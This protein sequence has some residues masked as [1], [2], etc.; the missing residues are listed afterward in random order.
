MTD[1]QDSAIS[2]LDTVCGSVESVCLSFTEPDDD[3]VPVMQT[4]TPFG[5]AFQVYTFGFDVA[6][7]SNDMAKDMLAHQMMVPLIESTGAKL[8]ATVFSTWMLNARVTKDNLVDG[9]YVG[10]RP[11]DSPDRIEAVMVSVIAPTRITTR[12]AEII[13]D[14]VN[15]PTL[16]A[17]EQWGSDGAVVFTGRFTEPLQ[18]ALRDSSGKVDL[19][20]MEAV[21]E[22][23][24]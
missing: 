19:Q 1:M 15:P 16:S 20:R 4:A 12:H 5:D 21:F 17:W 10:P 14:E 7:L 8:V 13:R 9:R 24:Q 2:F 22:E 18:D 23:G 6:Y 11:S 3:F